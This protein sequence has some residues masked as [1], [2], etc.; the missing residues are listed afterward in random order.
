MNI[1]NALKR[2]R[3][4]TTSFNQQEF[5]GKLG[6]SQTYLSQIE[7]GKKTPSMD[8]I[9]VYGRLTKVPLAVL[10]WMAMEEKDVKPSKKKIFKELKPTIDNLI[11]EII[12]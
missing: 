8:L 5:A 6:I 10:L 3:K 9:E 2:L 1:A 12:Y 4:E 11:R 7:G